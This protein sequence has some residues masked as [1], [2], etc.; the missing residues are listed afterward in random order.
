[1]TRCE[2]EARWR[3]DGKRR[4]QS[5]CPTTSRPVRSSRSQPAW[6]R[7]RRNSGSTTS[8]SVPG[9]GITNPFGAEIGATMGGPLCD[10]Y[11]RKF[12]YTY[13]LILY[14]GRRAHRR[15]RIHLRHAPGGVHRFRHRSRRRHP[16]SWTCIAENAPAEKRAA[17]IGSAQFAWSMGPTIGL[18]LAVVLGRARPSRPC[19][20]TG[21]SSFTCSSSHSSLGT[22]GKDSPSP[23][24]GGRTKPMSSL[25]RW[26]SSCL[27]STP[28][29]EWK[30]HL[31]PIPF[32]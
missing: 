17:H 23:R 9:R 20:A 7:G 18:L 21:S 30:P 14:I 26:A 12:T 3:P 22:S 5:R 13:D 31:A 19:S 15:V 16:A 6:V 2:S 11:R 10:E 32:N 8:P 29:P 1:M 4:S 27:A 28:P 25:V 24:S